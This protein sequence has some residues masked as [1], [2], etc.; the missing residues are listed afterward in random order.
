VVLIFEEALNTSNYTVTFWL[1]Q[2]LITDPVS[3]P[4]K[5]G[6]YMKHT[7]DPQKRPLEDF[8]QVLLH[9]H[10]HCVI[11]RTNIVRT[12]RKYREKVTSIFHSSSLLPFSVP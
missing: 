7:F 8:R 2:N 9:S 10:L 4:I 12:C 5:W 1:Q 3:P 11:S 6:L